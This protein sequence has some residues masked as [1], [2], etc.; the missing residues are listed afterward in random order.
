MFEEVW[1]LQWWGEVGCT[2]QERGRV[3]EEIRKNGHLHH[4][5]KY[6]AE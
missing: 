2:V 6:R 4:C 1:G 5:R 3:S